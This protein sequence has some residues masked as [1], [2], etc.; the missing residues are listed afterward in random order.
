MS[1]KTE[2]SPEKISKRV[3]HLWVAVFQ[4]DSKIKSTYPYLLPATLTKAL[5]QKK[6][7]EPLDP[8]EIM[9]YHF[10]GLM[11]RNIRAKMCGTDMCQNELWLRHRYG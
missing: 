11:S 3:E 10:Q 9:R 2:Y 6:N 5:G 4:F 8:L 7:P 1:F